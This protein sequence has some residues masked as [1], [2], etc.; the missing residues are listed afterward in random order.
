MAYVHL[1]KTHVFHKPAE[2]RKDIVYVKLTTFPI[3]KESLN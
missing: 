3:K 1:E 2:L